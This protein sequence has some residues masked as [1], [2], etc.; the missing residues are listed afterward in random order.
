L[1]E[2]S[3]NDVVSVTR[4]S[5]EDVVTGKKKLQTYQQKT[6]M[7]IIPPYCRKKLQTLSKCKLNFTLATQALSHTVAAA[8]ETYVS[9]GSLLSSALW[10]SGVS[11]E[12]GPDI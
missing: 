12:A 9:L 6:A 10:N 11:F 8:V 3:K 4:S 7:E 5:K 2:T 1:Q